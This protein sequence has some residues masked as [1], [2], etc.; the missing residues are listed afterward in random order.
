MEFC[1]ASDRNVL[2]AD[3]GLVPGAWPSAL[4]RMTPYVIPILETPAHP[5][6]AA[7]PQSLVET[8]AME[9]ALVG[10]VLFDVGGFALFRGVRMM[11]MLPWFLRR[12]R[13]R[14]TRYIFVAAVARWNRRHLAHGQ[15]PELEETSA[16]SMRLG[17]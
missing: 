15:N 1:D 12:S 13:G 6:S 16:I 17:L 3:Q 4:C 9:E 8:T 10:C 5:S 2:A 11:S 14:A 7:P